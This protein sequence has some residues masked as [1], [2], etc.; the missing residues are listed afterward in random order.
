VALLIYGANGYTGALIAERAAAKGVSAILAGRNAE[1]VNVL[2]SKLGCPA[3]VFGLSDPDATATA[4]DGVAVV[5]NCAGPFSRTAGPLVDAC[6]R[7]RA[8]YLDIT[9]EL[10]VIEA[11][12]ARDAE[13]RAAAITLLPAAGFDVVPSDCLAAQAKHRLPT[14]THLALAFHAGTRMSR[15]TA[16]TSIENM[17]GGG[18]NRRDGKITRVPSGWRTR[19]ID[20][21]D[22][23]RKAVTI[24]WGDVASAYH[25]TGIPNVEVY[26]A[27][28][29]LL[30]VG[31]RAARWVGPLLASAPLQRFLKSRVA[32]GPEGPDADQRAGGASL[33]WAEARDGAGH[34]VTLRLRAPEAY[35]LT[36]WT[37]LELAERALRGELPVGFQTPARACGRDFVL[38][39]PGVTLTADDAA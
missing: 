8:H 34:V 16:T 37:A 32:R 20:F 17:N 27:V 11:L 1:V 31:L 36:T 4:L 10:D 26:V 2:A 5:L 6:L 12:A 13:A 21:G 29:A 33:L 23:P 15:G 30:R 24:P 38:G 19:A 9:G 25:T 28:P 3:R 39:F 7:V 35:Q 18:A 22:G 14:A